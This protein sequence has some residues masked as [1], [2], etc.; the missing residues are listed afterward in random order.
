MTMRDVDADLLKCATQED[1]IGVEKALRAGANPNACDDKGCSVLSKAAGNSLIVVM[2]LMQAGGDVNLPDERGVTPLMCAID[3]AMFANA[4]HMID[5]GGDLSFQAVA[6]ESWTALHMAVDAD[7]HH[8]QIRRTQFVLD[9]LQDAS[10]LMQWDGQKIT[11]AGMAAQLDQRRDREDRELSVVFRRYF[12]KQFDAL[13]AAKE[14]ARNAPA[15][16]EKRRREAAV[17]AQEKLREQAGK[18]RIRFKP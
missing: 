10:L 8:Q 6:E 17:Q 5:Q 2:R 9:R 13:C 4:Q 15:E 14:A 16:L 7:N 3:K 12:D 11:A 1:M 18:L